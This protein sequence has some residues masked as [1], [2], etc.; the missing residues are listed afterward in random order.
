MFLVNVYNSQY[1]VRVHL[2]ILYSSNTMN[3]SSMST[4]VK[5]I[6]DGISRAP[7]IHQRMGVTPTLHLQWNRTEGQLIGWSVNFFGIGHPWYVH[8]VWRLVYHRSRWCGLQNIQSA[9]CIF[10]WHVKSQSGTG[11]QRQWSKLSLQHSR[12]ATFLLKQKR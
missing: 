10:P 9:H 4:C 1:F 8:I 7:S 5:T 2:W 6:C 12:V 3:S 11:E